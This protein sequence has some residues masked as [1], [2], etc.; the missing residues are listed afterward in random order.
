MEIGVRYRYSATGTV[1]P[2]LYKGSGIGRERNKEERI[3]DTLHTQL[4]TVWKP[5]SV[6]FISVVSYSAD[7]QRALL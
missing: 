7:Q 2:V 1:P 5:W 3:Y 6:V 4:T